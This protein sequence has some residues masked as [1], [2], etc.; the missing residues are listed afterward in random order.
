[1]PNELHVI[2]LLP[3]YALGSLDK[4]ETV[5]VSE[6]LAHCPTCQAELDAYLAVAGQLAFA[7]REVVPP[8][9]VKQQIMQRIERQRAPAD[10]LPGS[11]WW[12]QLAGLFRRSAPAWALASLILIVALAA[13][14]IWLWQRV[15]DSGGNKSGRMQ[16]VALAP[17]EASPGATGTLVISMDGEY[18]TLVVD[19]LP[20]LEGEQQYQIW[21]VRDGQYTSGGVFSVNQHGYGAFEIPAPE[22]LASYPS[23]SV[24]V[25][26]AG[27]S[28]GPTGERVLGGSL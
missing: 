2:E 17:T 28:P 3:A 26:P 6:H 9:R 20:P 23:F 22:P 8:A 19:G 5:H 12:Q 14:S 21:L 10:P 25:E 15:E 24:T 27:G 7:A 4:G 1:M 18:G 13:S 11:G 16:V